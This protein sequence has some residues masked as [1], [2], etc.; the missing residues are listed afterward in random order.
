MIK[1]DQY[2]IIVQ[3]NADYPDQADG[4]D[5]AARTGIMALCGSKQ[6]QNLLYEFVVADRLIRHPMQTQWCTS[7]KTSRDQLVQWAAGVWQYKKEHSTFMD[8]ALISYARSWTINKDVLTPDVRLYLYKCVHIDAPFWLK[9][10]GYPWLFLSLI[11][12]T[13]VTPN[14]EQNKMFCV[15]AVMGNWWLEKLYKWHPRL[16]GNLYSYWCG[17]PWR[18]QDEV[19]KMMTSYLHKRLHPYE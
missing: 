13:K 4:G 5:S 15:C 2:G 9:L 12:S 14:A 16:S 3:H 18:D 8:F 19:Y 17:Y 6:D 7:D 11:W 1:R 10:I